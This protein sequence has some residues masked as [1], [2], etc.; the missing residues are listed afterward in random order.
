MEALH[1]NTTLL[2]VEDDDEMRAL[3]CKALVSH[4]FAVN[5]AASAADAERSALR[6]PPAAIVLDLGLPDSKGTGLIERLREHGNTPIIVLSARSSDVDKVSALDAGAD[7]YVTKPFSVLELLAR[8]RVALRDAQRIKDVPIVSA[9]PIRIDQARNEVTVNGLHVRLTRIEQRLLF[10]LARHVGKVRTRQQLLTA[11]WGP[12]KV[13]EDHYLRVHV[14]ALRRKLEGDPSDPRWLVTEQG[15]G[16]R[17]R[18]VAPIQTER[19][20]VRA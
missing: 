13:H 15:I 19:D 9:G 10:E 6:S 3:L 20:A 11:V 12:D 18:D 8:L 7:D 17:L 2:V 1:T 4:G 14:A 16:Y 5:Q